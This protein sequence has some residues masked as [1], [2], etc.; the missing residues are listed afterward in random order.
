MD[1]RIVK[2]KKKIHDAFIL[3][4]KYCSQ[5]KIKVKDICAEANI[6]KT[7]FYKHYVDSTELSSEIDESLA[8]GIVESFTEKESLFE[9]PEEYVEGL[10][11]VL[12]R[13]SEN[14]TTV[15]KGRMEV[16]C[17]KL[18]AKLRRIYEHTETAAEKK[19]ITSFVIG[20]IVRVLIERVFTSKSERCD[21]KKIS[22]YLL[23][24]IK[25][26]IPTT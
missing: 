9:H 18:E 16:L 12:D 2:T 25:R 22:T 4:R 17:A 14:L 26:V 6:N 8:E 23:T 10:T 5:D 21:K 24:M 15:Y 19:V 20:G 1:R 11:E 3:L 13:D 7:T